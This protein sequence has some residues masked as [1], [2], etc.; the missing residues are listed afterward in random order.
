MN[1]S[2]IDEILQEIQN[3]SLNSGGYFQSY[4]IEKATKSDDCLM[5][6]KNE[7]NQIERYNNPS[8][9]G[10]YF[11]S[12]DLNL[13]SLEKIANWEQELK[14]EI[15]Y[16]TNFELIDKT[17]VKQYNQ[18]KIDLAES[19]LIDILKSSVEKFDLFINLGK[20][21]TD[22][23]LWGDHITKDLYFEFENHIFII[24][25]GWSS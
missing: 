4:I 11:E 14:K 2:K 1:K 23:A 9:D 21:D 8:S 25:F 20:F 10:Q 19:K 7:L 22:F 24:H 3:N 15:K 5:A 6:L 13:I 12:R 18:Q 16:W 17:T